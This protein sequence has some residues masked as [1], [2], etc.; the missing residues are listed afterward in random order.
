MGL[1][2]QEWQQ[3]LTMWG[4]VESDLAGHGHAVLMR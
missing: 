3:V 2:D 1:S 4:K